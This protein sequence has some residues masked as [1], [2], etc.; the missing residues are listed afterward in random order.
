MTKKIS[1]RDFIRLSGTVAGATLLA[2]CAPAAAPATPAVVKE[3]VQVPVKETVQVP[4]KETVIATAAPKPAGKPI[5]VTFWTFINDHAN[6]HLGRV[7]AWNAGNPDRPIN[8]KPSTLP[9]E[10]MHNK[11]LL[12]LQAGTGAPDLVDIEISRFGNYLKGDDSAIGLVDLASIIDKNKDQLMPQR[13]SVYSKAGHYYGAPTHLGA[14]LMFYNDSILKAAGVDIDKIQ[15]WDDFIAAGKQVTKG[16]VYMTMIDNYFQFFLLAQMNGGG[17]MDKDGNLV[18]NQPANVEA[19]QFIQGLIFKH[20]IAKINPGP[21]L[22]SPESY[23]AINAGKMACVWAPEW[24]VGRFGPQ[25]PDLSGK[26]RIRPIPPMKP[27]GY[28]AAMG[29]GTGTAITKQIAKEKL[30]TALDYLEFAKL[31][32]Q[33]N[34]AIWK[35]LHFDPFRFDAYDDSSMND[36]NPYFSN[37]KIMQVVKAEAKNLAPQ[38][39]GPKVPQVSVAIN[40]IVTQDAFVKNLPAADILKRVHDQVAAQQ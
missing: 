18:L 11:L 21:G 31:S 15:T 17:L 39:V 7:D 36:P 40:E 1:R 14:S 13:V 34:L 16:D 4:V 26:M 27:G 30:Q 24:F 23:A 20:K 2:A 9:Y 33:G 6:F 29:G 5:D 35:I 38:Y 3:T 32:L 22:D 12:S 25:I 10:D 8:L 19:L 28:T 37:E